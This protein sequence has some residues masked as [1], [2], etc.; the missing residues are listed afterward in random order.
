MV[1]HM[2]M[3]NTNSG[4]RIDQPLLFTQSVTT[5][6]RKCRM[7]SNNGRHVRIQF[8]PIKKNLHVAKYYNVSRAITVHY[9]EL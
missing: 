4:P 3:V 6:F 8:F 5:C 9:S 2:V 1:V 7:E